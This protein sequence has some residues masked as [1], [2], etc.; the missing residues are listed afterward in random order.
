[1]TEKESKIIVPTELV[2]CVTRI[3]EIREEMG[4][5]PST[6]DLCRA[7]ILA[8]MRKLVHPT[9]MEREFMKC[10]EETMA[11]GTGYED[12][13]RSEMCGLI[14][15]AR[16]CVSGMLLGKIVRF[17]GTALPYDEAKARQFIHVEAV[18]ITSHCCGYVYMY[19]TLYHYDDELC[20]TSVFMFA[21]A[22]DRSR[23]VRES[24]EEFFSHF[25]FCDV[26]DVIVSIGNKK[27]EEMKKY[28]DLMDMFRKQ[29]NESRLSDE[30]CHPEEWLP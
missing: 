20:K 29:V 21:L 27:A 7:A 10:L 1:M 22:E 19:G 16:K 11:N 24:L 17:V 15:K 23:P 26:D 6:A 12:R 13:L 14:E 4:D 18:N 28:D 2:K 9:E 8:D 25:R 3:R 5:E 30:P